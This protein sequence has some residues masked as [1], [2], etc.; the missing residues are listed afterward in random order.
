MRPRGATGRATKHGFA[1]ALGLI[2]GGLPTDADVFGWSRRTS[3]L[4]NVP[5][6]PVALVALF[7]IPAFSAGLVV[8]LAFAAGLQGFFLVFAQWIQLGS[9]LSP[10]G[11]GLTTVARL[12]P[13]RIVP[14]SSSLALGCRCR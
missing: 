4:I 14:G 7:R 2:L 13:R 1:P 9:G 6:A 3:F 11:A 10:P 5:I 12:D 8:Q